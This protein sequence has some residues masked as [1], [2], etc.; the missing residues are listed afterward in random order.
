MGDLKQP[1]LGIMWA[2][3]ED[4]RPYQLERPVVCF[5]APILPRLVSRPFANPQDALI[6]R[7]PHASAHDQH[8]HH[9]CAIEEVSPP[10]EQPPCLF[11][12]RELRLFPVN[13]I[14][15]AHSLA[16]REATRSAFQNASSFRS[17]TAYPFC[18]GMAG[19]VP[20]RPGE[21]GQGHHHAGNRSRLCRR[22][23]R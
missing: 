12:S 17:G 16:R 8:G 9:S 6:I 13:Y 23:G 2:G 10:Q 7:A 14:P 3:G 20:S 1:G 22:Q 21:L 18:G 19:R 4:R 15:D 5:A 11:P